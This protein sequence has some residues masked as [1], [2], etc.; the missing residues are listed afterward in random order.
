MANKTILKWAGSKVQIMPQLLP[1]LP[2]TQRLVEPF[3][4]SCAVM[5]KTDYESYLLADANPDLI[6]FYEMMIHHNTVFIEAV[7][8]LF[9]PFART[10]SDEKQR[11]YRIRQQFNYQAMTLLWRAVSFLYLNKH[12][13]NGLCRYN[14]KGQFNVPAGKYKTVY[15][16]EK[17]INQFIS[18]QA[19]SITLRCRD[20]SETLSLVTKDDGIYCDPPY[21]AHKNG[22]TQYCPEKFTEAEHEKLAKRLKKMNARRGNPITV[23]NSIAAK[24]LYADL[25]FMVHEISAPRKISGKRQ[26]AKE[27]IAVLGGQ[28]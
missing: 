2:K 20:W 19:Q 6:N 14:Q 15:F 1:H 23:S 27:I 4:G 24:S 21:L 12:G 5:M 7:K 13:F 22:F 9:S 17:E 8:S 18:R 11:Y 10:G 16:P 28:S 25:G 3:A 26:M